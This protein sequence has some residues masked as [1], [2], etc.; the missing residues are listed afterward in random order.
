MK[1][2]HP[3]KPIPVYRRW[4]HEPTRVRAVAVLLVVTY[5]LSLATTAIIA[6]LL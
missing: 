1:P 4:P 3:K 5:A 2:R 6:W